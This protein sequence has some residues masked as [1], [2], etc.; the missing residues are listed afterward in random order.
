MTCACVFFSAKQ[1]KMYFLHCGYC[2]NKVAHDLYLE[3]IKVADGYCH[4]VLQ[5]EPDGKWSIFRE[6]DYDVWRRE[7]WKL[8]FIMI[9]DKIVKCDFKRASECGGASVASGEDIDFFCNE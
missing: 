1:N 3:Y 4:D 2:P 6:V 5:E 8:R 7:E 9:K